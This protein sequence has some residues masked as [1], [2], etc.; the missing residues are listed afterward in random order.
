[1]SSEQPLLSNSRLAK[2]SD[3]EVLKQEMLPASESLLVSG[4]SILLAA[5]KLLIHPDAHNSIK[6]LVASAKRTLVETIKV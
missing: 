6:E 5:Q 2:E 1:M 4:K 3:D